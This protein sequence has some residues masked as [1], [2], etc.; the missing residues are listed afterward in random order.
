MDKV[1][2]QTAANAEESAS[3]S[4]Q[5]TAQAEQMR[6]Y[7][8]DLAVAIGGNGAPREESRPPAVPV[9]GKAK[10]ALHKALAPTPTGKKPA[11]PARKQPRP[12][13]VIPLE[14]GDFKDF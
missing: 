5:L 4:E 6:V 9:G 1:T 10:A 14:E 13:Q 2:Q 11:S 8:G 12:E 7:V 3:A